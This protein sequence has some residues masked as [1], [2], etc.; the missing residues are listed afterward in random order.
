MRPVGLIK[1]FRTVHGKVRF[2]WKDYRKDG[3]TKVMTSTPRS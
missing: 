2:T 3:V 1:R